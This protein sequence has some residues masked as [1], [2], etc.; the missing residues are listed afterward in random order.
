MQKTW[1][2][3]KVWQ[4]LSIYKNSLT[5]GGGWVHTRL[6]KSKC[7]KCG[8]VW[9]ENVGNCSKQSH[10]GPCHVRG[11]WERL[12]Y[13]IEWDLKIMWQM[14]K[15]SWQLPNKTCQIT[16]QEMCQIRKVCKMGWRKWPKQSQMATRGTNQYRW[17]QQ[18]NGGRPS[19]GLHSFGCS[20]VQ[21]L[22]CGEIGRRRNCAVVSREQNAS[23]SGFDLSKLCKSVLF[24]GMWKPSP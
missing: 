16:N 23:D 13:K 6:F 9:P 7:G 22:S 15:K 19:K 2:T 10:R 17:V 12:L 20:V 8:K 1:Q 24:W 21:L 4:L 18:T 14:L 3:S 11:W 5:G